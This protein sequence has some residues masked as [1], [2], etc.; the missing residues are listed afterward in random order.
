[1]NSPHQTTGGNVL[2][3]RTFEKDTEDPLNHAHIYME[4]Q[5]DIMLV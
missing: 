4:E 3:R 5:P 1:M 2:A